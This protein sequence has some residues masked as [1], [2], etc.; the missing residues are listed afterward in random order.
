[1]AEAGLLEDDERPAVAAL[2]GRLGPLQAIAGTDGPDVLVGTAEDDRIDALGGNDD[3]EGRGGDDAIFG[4]GGNDGVRG[5]AGDD[6]IGGGAGD[7]TAA[8]GS[9]TDRLA[10]G[11]GIDQLSGDGGDDRISGGAGNDVLQGG[12]GGDRLSGGGGDDGLNGGQ[13]SD[14]L[15]GGGGAD[16]LDGKGAQ[17]ILAGGAGEDVFAFTVGDGTLDRVLDFVQGEDRIDLSALLPDFEPGDDLDSFVRLEVVP[18]GTLLSIDPSGS[19]ADF[20][21]LA[22]LEGVAITELSPAELGLAGSLPDEVTVVSTNPA[23][24]PANTRALNPSL[25][26]DGRFITFA[27]DADNLVPNDTNRNSDIFRKDLTTG[28]VE[29]VTQIRVPGQGVQQ[30]DGLSLSPAISGNGEVV[31]FTS[32]AD[33]LSDVDTGRGNV[34]VTA[35]GSNAVQ[36]VSIV[37]NLMAGDPSIDD[38]GSRVAFTATASGR[39]ETDDPAPSDTIMNRVYVRD[40]SDGS[41]IEVSSDA[42]GNFADGPSGSAEISADG[43]FV[44]FASDA[45]N[46][47]ADGDTNR[48]SDIY[49]RSLIDGSIQNVSTTADG[50]QGSGDSTD[51]TVS[52]DGRFVAFASTASFVEEDLDND[53]DIYLKDLQTGELTL[54]TINADGI[55]G[56]SVSFSPSISDD[57]RFIAFRSRAGNLVAGDDDNGSEDL[58]VADTQTGQFL[59]IALEIDSSAELVPGIVQ[60]TISGNGELVTFVD[61]RNIFFTQVLAAPVDFQAGA[62]LEAEDVL[63]SDP[64]PVT[65]PATGGALTPGPGAAALPGPAMHGI[66]PAAELATLVIQPD[67][68]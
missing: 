10:G 65:G 3:V 41:L 59:R 18:E 50:S 9:G 27:S 64:A 14:Q 15:R 38:D 26:S 30:T 35:V 66:A 42:A 6:R 62:A 51:P 4:G 7:D 19:G 17:D 54:V 21:R 47:D 39:A 24:E 28:E 61:G 49:I 36:L 60:P 46:L 2:S 13:G 25:S 29:L 53:S 16:V 55:K 67:A 52:G 43:N 31:A 5:G 58:F 57:G 32:V 68:A 8:G 20:E 37:G 34:F 33:N 11:A 63:S 44:V 56:D 48:G 45:T 1:M 12:G 40:L 22:R 23:G